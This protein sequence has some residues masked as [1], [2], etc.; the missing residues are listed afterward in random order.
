V[1]QWIK[2]EEK[3]RKQKRKS[4]SVRGRKEMYLL[5]EKKL[6]EE[7]SERRAQ[8]KIVKNGGLFHELKNF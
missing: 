8:G 7:F 1:R 4:K 6:F 2:N 3:F 5:F